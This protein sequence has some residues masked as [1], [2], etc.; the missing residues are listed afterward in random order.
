MTSHLGCK[1]IILSLEHHFCEVNDEGRRSTRSHRR[2][3][4]FLSPSRYFLDGLFLS[5]DLMEGEPLCQCSAA[6]REGY[7]LEAS[8]PQNK[9]SF[10]SSRCFII[11]ASLVRGKKKGRSSGSAAE[12]NLIRFGIKNKPAH[13][14][15]VGIQHVNKVMRD[16]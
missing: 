13:G 7:V 10:H 9:P 11:G 16:D 6:E 15:N 4:T 2:E 5:A 3:N 14:G 1:S 12:H 8:A